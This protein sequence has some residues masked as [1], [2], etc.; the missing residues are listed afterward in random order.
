MKHLS[1]NNAIIYSFD[2]THSPA[3]SIHS[4]ETVEV[5][6]YDC[7]ENQIDANNNFE[8]INWSRINPA[9]GPIEIKDAQAG[10]ILKIEI[11]RIDVEQQGVMI[12]GA[13]IGVMGDKLTG[14]TQKLVNI[15]N[16]YVSFDEQLK[17][18]LQKMIGVIGVAP[19]GEPIPT[20]TPGAHGGN[21]DT[22]LITEGN[23]LYLPVWV[24]GALLALG[25]LHA[26]M[27]DGEISGAGVEVAGKTTL[28]IECI[29]RTQLTYTP[30][31]PMIETND[32]LVFLAS[33][34][35][36]NDA[37]KQATSYAIEYISHLTPLSFEHATLLMSAIGDAQISQVVDPLITARFRVPKTALQ[38][39]GINHAISL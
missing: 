25:D 26:A 2:K 16:N 30:Q 31:Q 15:T 5:T 3:L 20:G 38:A 28:H 6:S 9:T 22:K 18:P 13:G 34:K 8:G 39:Y 21:L 17:F 7:F 35:T 12:T 1:C 33:E 11:K 36:L 27:G 24:D 19:A 10:D 37:V 14:M 4:G 29:K 32:S 23:I